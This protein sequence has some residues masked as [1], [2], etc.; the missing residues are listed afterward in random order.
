M[1]VFA[2]NGRAGENWL[3]ERVRV[4]EFPLYFSIYDRIVWGCFF[5]SIF[6]VF[7]GC[8]EYINTHESARTCEGRSFIRRWDFGWLFTYLGISAKKMLFQDKVQSLMT[9]GSVVQM[10]CM[11]IIASA[12]FFKQHKKTKNGALMIP[13]RFF[14]AGMNGL[15]YLGSFCCRDYVMNPS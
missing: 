1:L 3:N 7:C 5:S 13:V 12:M 11:S 14:L 8:F 9:C 6:C 10:T 4:A 15:L 2:W